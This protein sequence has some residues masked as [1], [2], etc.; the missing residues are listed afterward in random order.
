MHGVPRLRIYRFEVKIVHSQVHDSTRIVN[1]SSHRW[2]FKLDLGI[3]K[4]CDPRTRAGGTLVFPVDARNPVYLTLDL[5]P[6]T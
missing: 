1:L 4:A 5:A 6:A 3:S 2:S